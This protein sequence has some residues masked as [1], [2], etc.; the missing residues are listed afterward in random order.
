[1]I[2]LIGVMVF[3]SC[4]MP[5]GPDT[6]SESA[7]GETSSEEVET[8]SVTYKVFGDSSVSVDVNGNHES[9]TVNEEWS[10][11]FDANSES[12]FLYIS[13][14]ND[15]DLGQICVEIL[16]NEETIG[17][18][19]STEEYGIASISGSLDDMIKNPQISNEPE[20]FFT[21]ESVVVESV[22]VQYDG[23]TV[24]TQSV[25]L[26]VVVTYS[27]GSTNSTTEAFTATNPGV[28]NTYTYTED[29][30]SD[31][32][33]IDFEDWRL[34][35]EWLESSGHTRF[36]YNGTYK[37]INNPEYEWETYVTEDGTT[38]IQF[39][40]NTWDDNEYYFIDD[41]TMMI[42]VTGIIYSHEY[43]LTLQ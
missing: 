38:M 21:E 16:I 6:S 39:H 32:V 36:I 29:G 4:Q 22:E 35:G 33:D 19:Y 14:Q 25:D 9:H 31:S 11:S 17:R 23:S 20:N 7:S 24:Y 28:V 13:S 10:Y 37:T 42:V 8:Y 3:A 18:A 1:M 34:V 41:E 40:N 26:E 12:Q 27:D 2:V 43:T 5:M 30:V 15:D